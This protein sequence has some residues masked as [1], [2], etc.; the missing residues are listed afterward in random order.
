MPPPHLG[1]EVALAPT[2]KTAARKPRASTSD[3][4]RVKEQGGAHIAGKDGTTI[5]L[6][7]GELVR[8]SHPIL[9]SHPQYFEKLDDT[10]RPE[11]EQ[12]TAAPGEQ[13]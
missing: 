4:Y 12:A 8:G 7:Q 6:R 2:R 9:K 5:T 11:V 13:R 3:W 10:D 1:R